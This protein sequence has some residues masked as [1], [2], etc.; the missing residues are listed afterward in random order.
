MGALKGAVQINRAAA[1]RDPLTTTLQ[2]PAEK[3]SEAFR[4]AA[5]R[6][7]LDQKS[8]AVQEG[9]R[10]T[11]ELLA[12][13]NALCREHNAQLVV[14]VIPTKETV[15]ADYL[16]KAPDLHLRPVIDD[17]IENEKAA[18]AKLTAFLNAQGIPHIETLGALRR[19]VANEL[20]TRS[21]RDMHPGKNGY[22]VIGDEVARYLSAAI[23][24]H[25]GR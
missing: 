14:V 12:R 21:D 23:R 5:I 24:T 18:T 7:R 2:V 6:D 8:A 20:Y 9:M 16:R 25:A 19:D 4:P 13:M 17:L 1:G 3:I 15:F 11:F 22:R 10:V